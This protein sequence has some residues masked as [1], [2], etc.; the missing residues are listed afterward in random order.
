MRERNSRKEKIMTIE[1][2]TNRDYI[3]KRDY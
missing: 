1:R 3:L 2:Q